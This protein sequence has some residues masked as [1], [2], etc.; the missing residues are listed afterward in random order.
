MLTSDVFDILRDGRPRTRA[1]LAR[2]TGLARSTIAARID[3]LMKLGLIIPCGGVSTG[4]R[5]PS[6]FALNPAAR[7]VAG[8]GVPLPNPIGAPWPPTDEIT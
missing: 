5:P 8:G 4:G 1:Q 6:L 2:S 7:V 3:V